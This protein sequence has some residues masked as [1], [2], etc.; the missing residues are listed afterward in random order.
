MYTCSGLRAPRLLFQFARQLLLPAL[1]LISVQPAQAAWL[2]LR[3][4]TGSPQVRR[5]DAARQLREYRQRRGVPTGGARTAFSAMPEAT[6]RIDK[7]FSTDRK[8]TR[9]NS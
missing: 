1:I 8:S 7:S 6:L 2:R 5:M 3:Q 4:K 9:L